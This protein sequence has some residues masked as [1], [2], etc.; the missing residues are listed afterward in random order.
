MVSKKYRAGPC[1]RD[2]PDSATGTQSLKPQR[3]RPESLGTADRP[4]DGYRTT[5]DC[6]DCPAGLCPARAAIIRPMDRAV[7]DIAYDHATA[8]LAGVG[9]E[10]R[11]RRRVLGRAGRR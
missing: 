9:R 8:L 1:C 10:L 7:A 6:A 5:F 2:S 11:A 3:R 4:F